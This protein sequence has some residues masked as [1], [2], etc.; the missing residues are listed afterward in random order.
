ML[1]KI[2]LC[3]RRLPICA[4]LALLAACVSLNPPYQPTPLPIPARYAATAGAASRIEAAPALPPWREYFS[5]PRLQALIEHALSNNRDLRVAVLRVQEAR[6]SYGIQRAEQYPALNAQAAVDRSRTPADLNLSQRVLLGNQFQ[7]GFG[8]SSWEIDFWGRVA[9]LKEAALEN[10]LASDESRRAVT[11]SLIYQLANSYLVW[12]ELDER[13]ALAKQSLSSRAETLRIFT[14]RTEVGANSRLELSQMRSLFIQAQAL[15]AQLEQARSAQAQVLA[16]LVGTD[17]A[18]QLPAGA[19]EHPALASYPLAELAAGLPSDLLVQRP[20]LMAAEHLLRAAN[21]NI[22]AA[23]AAFFPRVALTASYGTASAEL[24]GLFDAGSSA[25]L[26]SPSISLPI[27][28]A[29]RLRNSLDLAELRRDIALAQYERSIQ[30]AFRDV[31]DALA[32]RHWLSQ[33][34]DIAQAALDTQRERA[35]L[36]QLRYDNGAT[37]FLDVLDAQRELL[38]AEQQRVQVQRAWLSSQLALYSALGGGLPLT[39]R[40]SASIDDSA[41]GTHSP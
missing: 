38:S 29:G 5:E 25:W 16:L 21:A 24:S 8:F 4:T 30:S 41:Q 22:G 7:L 18:L 37:A 28:N 12:L 1:A 26:F 20:E 2:P 27:F 32:A 14:R 6:A 31:A 13:I 3:I 35:R 10:F 39:E 19:A 15:L 23:R 17:T 11:L 40:N 9:S 36:A 33:Q 34:R